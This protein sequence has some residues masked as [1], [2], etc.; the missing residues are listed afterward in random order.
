MARECYSS[1]MKQKAVNNI[2]M[3]ELDLRDEVLTG[4]EPSEE[5]EL[6]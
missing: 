4:L 3:D 6:V 1:S 5:L 2:Y